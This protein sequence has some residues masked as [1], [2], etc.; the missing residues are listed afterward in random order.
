MRAVACVTMFSAEVMSM[1]PPDALMV[2]SLAVS[3]PPI[4]T[5][6]PATITISPAFRFAE[7]SI[8]PCV[9]PLLTFTAPV[10]SMRTGRRYCE[11]QC[12]VTEAGELA[13]G[14]DGERPRLDRD[15]VRQEVD[16]A[17]HG[18]GARPEVEDAIVGDREVFC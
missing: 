9:V 12:R 6:P 18:H 15:R 4:V 3:R 17:G 1:L 5:M 14:G 10:V 16:R 2:R 13:A 7:T 11:A 8:R